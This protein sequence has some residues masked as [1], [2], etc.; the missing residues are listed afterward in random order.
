MSY[1][2]GEQKKEGCCEV[3]LREYNPL[4]RF[5]FLFCKQYEVDKGWGCGCC[6]CRAFSFSLGVVIFAGV[7][8]INSIKDLL[9]IFNSDYLTR[10]SEDSKD[11][12]DYLKGLVFDEKD[13]TFIIFFYLKLVADFLCIGAALIAFISLCSS[14]HCI[15][16][17][18][19]YVG[20]ISFALNTSFLIFVITRITNSSFWSQIGITSIG[21]VFLWFGFEYVWLLFTWMLFCNMVDIKR[22]NDNKKED[23]YNFG[24]K[25]T[26]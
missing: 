4:N 9:E 16:I 13:E 1:Y 26:N 14:N 17:V 3:C 21:N 5:M 8:L 6:G 23:P 7:M 2:Y 24:Y 18:S 25:S 20:F 12:L 11:V 22:K 10:K 19:Y 15:A